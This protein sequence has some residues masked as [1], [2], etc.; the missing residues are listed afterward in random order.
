MPDDE[1][2]ARLEA[3]LKLD[4][5]LASLERARPER[6]PWW[7]QAPLVVAYGG[8]LALVPA[9]VTG[10]SGYFQNQRQFELSKRE[11]EQQQTLAYLQ[12]AVDAAAPEATRAQVLRFLVAI[13][14]GNAV[15]S[16]AQAELGLVQQKLDELAQQKQTVTADADD[17]D[18]KAAAAERDAAAAEAAA[19]ADPRQAP[20]AASK[21]AHAL[22]LRREADRKRDQLDAIA[23]RTGD[24]P[25]TVMELRSGSEAVANKPVVVDRVLFDRVMRRADAIES[26]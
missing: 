25:L 18:A 6:S 22:A 23:T 8:I 5:R 15:G 17:T 1:R 26:P 12:L 16:W 3:L 7:R 10:V 13:D 4:E 2:L 20:T 14:P 21:T 11:H 9:L 19:K 24:A